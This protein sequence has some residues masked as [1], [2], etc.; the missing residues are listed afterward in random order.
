[1]ADRRSHLIAGAGL[2][3]L[4]LACS[5]L[6]AGARGPIRLVDR[7]RAHEPDRT[8]CLWDT[9]DLRWAG[10]ARHRWRSW[11]VRTARGR[12]IGHSARHPYVHLD[13]ADVYAAAL[14]RLER[15]PNVALE[16][17]VRVRGFGEDADSAW[18]ETDAGP[19]EADRVYDALALGS[20]A[21]Q[22][23]PAGGAVHLW[24][25]FLGQLVETAEPVFTPSRCRLMDFRVA[26]D[27]ELRFV[28]VLPHGPHRALV[29]HTSI[30]ARPVPHGE[31]REALA[32]YLEVCGASRWTV[33]REERGRL[34]MTDAP[35]P[36][37]HGP[38]TVAV[39]TAAGAVRPSSGYAFARTVRHA[40][41]VARAILD[42]DVPPA[43]GGRRQAALDRI[44]LR[45]LRN[46]P[47]AFP[48][49]FRAL[50]AHTPG[51]AFA[52]FMSDASGPADEAAVVAALPKL[53]FAAAAAR[54]AL[55]TV[56]RLSSPA[57][58]VLGRAV[59]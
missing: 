18:L 8:W 10:L 41:R 20:P 57:A 56:P 54:T 39:G 31:R 2:A 1:M 5:L 9:G 28:Y 37:A 30:G 17:G 13:A 27:G 40:D 35:F 16:L 29:E 55:G 19:R 15:A 51:D 59:S 12:A 44:F 22:G 50:V 21:L 32:E 42:G 25:G 23:V 48:E 49:H 58:R 52:R 6:D 24:Q 4:A 34:P 47:A 45:A 11:E 43:P 46:D 33:E 7:R 14:E 38:R 36:L 53:P 3:G 26:Q